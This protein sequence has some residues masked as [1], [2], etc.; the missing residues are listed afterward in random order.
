MVAV[1]GCIKG[2][3]HNIINLTKFDAEKPTAICTSSSVHLC[4]FGPQNP[5]DKAQYANI[6]Q[7]LG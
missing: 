7:M 2:I 1:F 5:F 6:Y 4:N 3:L